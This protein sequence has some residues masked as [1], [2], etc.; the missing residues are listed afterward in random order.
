MIS[1]RCYIYLEHPHTQEWV[2]VGRYGMSS[3]GIGYFQY[4]SSYLDA[5]LPVP[6][7]PINLPLGHAPIPALRYDGVHDALRDACPDS[8]G[9]TLLKRQFGL[10]EN[11]THIAYLLKASNADRWGSLAV[12]TSRKPAIAHLNSPRLPDLEKLTRELIAINDRL[13]AV[14]A[15]LRR[16]ILA[17][18]SLGGARPKATVRDDRFF[19]LAKPV[20]PSDVIDTPLLEH[21]MQQWASEA[22]LYFA[23]TQYT[24]FSKARGTGLSVL[25]SRR[26]DR[27]AG[28][29][30]M[31]LSAASML[32]AEYP[33]ST[34]EQT[35]RW[36]YPRLA[37]ALVQ[38]GAPVQDR[39]ELFDRMAFNAIIGN[40]DD[41]PRNHAIYYDAENSGWRLSPAFD[42]VPE[43]TFAPID[44]SMRLSRDS[45][46]I[47]RQNI[48]AQ[49]TRFGFDSPQQAS[50]HLHALAHK[51]VTSYTKIQRLLTP[52]LAE[53]MRQR[54]THSLALLEIE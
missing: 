41:H 10:S 13:P 9:R 18:P 43:T 12:G 16:Q 54:L 47:S 44:L 42:V 53:I 29:R 31:T 8:W 4:A 19:W 24:S 26:F 50:A 11:A 25:L 51:F 40:N 3:E 38:V 49:A 1:D 34:P 23:P 22:G 46:A 37:D 48:L 36:S 14:D 28:H 52:E 5:P 35:R 17:T 6:I 7:D 32:Q 30:R 39:I 45:N 2:T 15:R 27:H 21:A 20:L 33:N